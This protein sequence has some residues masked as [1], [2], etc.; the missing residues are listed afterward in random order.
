MLK[1][2]IPAAAFAAVLLPTAATAQNIP[3]AVHVAYRDLDLRTPGGVRAF[4][5][6]IADAVEAVCPDSFATDLIRQH[7]VARCVASARAKVATQREAAL[8]SARR[9]TIELAARADR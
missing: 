3:A 1:Y 6:R 5:R 7:M 8:A 4:D 9:G 2:L